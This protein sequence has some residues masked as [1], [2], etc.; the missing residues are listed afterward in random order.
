MSASEGVTHSHVVKQHS[1]WPMRDVIECAD[2]C[3]VAVRPSK[4]EVEGPFDDRTVPG[5]LFIEV[6]YCVYHHKEQSWIARPY[7]N[8]DG[9][10]RTAV[11]LGTCGLKDKYGNNPNNGDTDVFE[12]DSKRDLTFCIISVA[13]EADGVSTTETATVEIPDTISWLEEVR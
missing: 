2:D 9:L 11:I 5:R 1:L 7:C 10:E 13:L 8:S 4:F 3:G 6:G 12:Y